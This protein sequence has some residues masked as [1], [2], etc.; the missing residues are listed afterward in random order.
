M[1]EKRTVVLS[2]LGGPGVGKS[3]LAALIFAELKLVRTSCEFVPEYAK[4]LAWAGMLGTSTK[5]RSAQSSILTEQLRRLRVLNGR[6]DVLVQDTC[7]LLP[8]IYGDADPVRTVQEFTSFQN[9]LVF[10]DRVIEYDP[11]GRRANKQSA[12]AMDVKIL[13]TL[14]TLGL[15]PLHAHP[16]REDAQRI[17]GVVLALLL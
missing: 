1:A 9:V 13:E 12:E 17:L 3:T 8:A 4:E 6:V 15:E 2:F 5:Q 14:N 16:T 11:E 7:V 10:V